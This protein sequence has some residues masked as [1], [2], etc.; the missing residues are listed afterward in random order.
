MFEAKKINMGGTIPLAFKL[1]CQRYCHY[2]TILDCSLTLGIVIWG[3]QQSA[4]LGGV[5]TSDVRTAFR[6]AFTLP[7]K[8]INIYAK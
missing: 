1:Q 4:K 6:L 5:L 7:E 2:L 8:T 3:C